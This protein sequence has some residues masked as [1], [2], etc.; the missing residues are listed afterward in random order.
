M[1][2]NIGYAIGN[3]KWFLGQV[4][5]CQNQHVRTAIWKDVHGDRVKVRIPGMHPMSSPDEEKELTDQELP[6]AIVAKPTTHG[7]RNAQST[8]IWGGEWV[9]GFFMD[10]DC[11]IPV[12]TQVLGNNLNE[13]TDTKFSDGNTKGKRIDRY[14]CGREPNQAEITGGPK[15]DSQAKP[16]ASELD[17]AK[18]A[19]SPSPKNENGVSLGLK[20]ESWD[21]GRETITAEDYNAV[22]NSKQSTVTPTVKYNAAKAAV[23]SGVITQ[24]QYQR[25]V[26]QLSRETESKR[27]PSFDVGGVRETK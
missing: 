2:D 27:I 22:F 26:A 23:N 6:W 8:G 18:T 25:S 16:T 21:G 24:K 15:P 14:N 12:I 4:P 7:N 13:D 11:Q 19:V 5:P 1:A 9:V 17:K 20:L 3:N 10:E